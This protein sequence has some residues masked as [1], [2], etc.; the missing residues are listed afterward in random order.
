MSECKRG[1]F[2]GKGLLAG[3]ALDW[4][5]TDDPE[6]LTYV[7]YGAVTGKS[8][9]LTAT[10]VDADTD[11]T[12][13]APDNIVVGAEAEATLSAYATDSDSLTSNQHAINARIAS[14]LA[15][16]GCTRAWVRMLLPPPPGGTHTPGAVYIYCNLT[17]VSMDAS[18]LRELVTAEL[19]AQMNDTYSPTYPAF[20]YIAPAV[21]TP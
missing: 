5:G 1:K 4:N 20:I 16:L 11:E 17:S 12:G 14:D 19:T 15:S 9:S 2:F 8:F 18:G 10:Q 7:S 3:I 21:I 6:T 13:F